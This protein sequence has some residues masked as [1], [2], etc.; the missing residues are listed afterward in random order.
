MWKTPREVSNTKKQTLLIGSQWPSLHTQQFLSAWNL[1]PAD[2]KETRGFSRWAPR[3]GYL[4]PNV[5]LWLNQVSTIKLAENNFTTVNI[6]KTSIEPLQCFPQ[7]MW[8]HVVEAL[9]INLHSC[10]MYNQDAMRPIRLLFRRVLNSRPRIRHW[11]DM[12]PLAEWSNLH[13][14][15]E[16][17]EE[18]LNN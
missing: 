15:D 6:F 4:H 13:K 17:E 10:W 9:L 3:K 18:R 1:P 16:D 5:K 12:R 14:T 7:P 11:C 2:F 8:V